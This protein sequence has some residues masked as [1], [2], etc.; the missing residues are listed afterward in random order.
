MF[1]T[2]IVKGSNI[3]NRRIAR[4]TIMRRTTALVHD[5]GHPKEWPEDDN[6]EEY[7]QP[8]KKIWFGDSASADIGIGTDGALRNHHWIA[9]CEF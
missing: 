4:G 2:T 1:H 6:H 5:Q 3:S 9:G 7:R 8:R